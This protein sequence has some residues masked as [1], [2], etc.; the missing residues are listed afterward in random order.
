[1]I[2][3]LIYEIVHVRLFCFDRR[4]WMSRA[5]TRIGIWLARISTSIRILVISDH[6]DNPCHLKSLEIS[7][8]VCILI[9]LHRSME[10]HIFLKNSFFSN[11]NIHM[12]IYWFIGCL[13]VTWLCITSCWFYRKLVMKA[14]QHNYKLYLYNDFL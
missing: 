5:V 6:N 4:N 13:Q 8:N 2:A 1:M 9:W 14:K 11:V 7:M 12:F 10:N 3:L